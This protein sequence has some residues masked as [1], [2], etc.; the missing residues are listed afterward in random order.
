MSGNHHP[1]DRTAAFT[2]LIVGA[3]AIGIMLYGIVLLTNA[4]Y[5]KEAGAPKPT[6]SAIR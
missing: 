4:Q 2:G 1:S 6:A 3:V 5:A